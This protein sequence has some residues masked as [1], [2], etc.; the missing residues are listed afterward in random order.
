NGCELCCKLMPISFKPPDRFQETK[1]WMFDHGMLH[2][3]TPMIPD[4]DK[5]AGKRCPHQK[6]GKGCA[7]Y[8][9]RP[10]GCRMWTC[11]WLDDPDTKDLR[12]PD[13]SHYVIDMS[14]DYVTW[15]NNDTGAKEH[16]PVVQIWIDPDYPLAHRDPALRQ[17]LEMYGARSIPALVRYDAPKAMR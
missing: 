2:P 10:F 7:V 1:Q 5:P 17:F 12:R 16:V 11:R 13:R 9:K 3:D 14:P 15:I 4:F 6:H 8:D